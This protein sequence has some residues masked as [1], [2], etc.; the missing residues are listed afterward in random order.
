MTVG[1][2]PEAITSPSLPLLSKS[3]RSQSKDPHAVPIPPNKLYSIN[4][5]MPISVQCVDS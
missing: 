2:P 1:Q 3:S 4:L 5:N